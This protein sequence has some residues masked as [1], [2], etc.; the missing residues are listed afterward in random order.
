MPALTV[1]GCPTTARLVEQKG[2]GAAKP[3]A[4]LAV[5][6]AHQGGA[7]KSAFLSGASNVRSAKVSGSSKASRKAMVTHAALAEAPKPSTAAAVEQLNFLTPEMAYKVANE[8]GTPCYV[9]DMETLKRQADTT[10]RFPNAYG[11]TVRYA[12]KSSPNA[13]ILQVFNAKG[14]HIDASSGFECIRAMEA[15]IPASHISLSSQELPAFFPDLCA[16]GVKVNCCSLSQLERYGQA[17]PGTKVG[18][19]FNPGMG[20][21]GNKKTNVGGTSSSFGI[22]HESLP[23]VQAIA[24]KYNLTVERIHTH[25]GSGSDPAVWQKVSGMSLDICRQF[26][27][28]ETLNLGGGYK[29]GR[30]EGEPSTDLELIGNPVVGEFEQFAEETGRKLRLEIEPG[31][32]LM[33]NSCSVVST[34]Q[35]VVSTGEDGYNFL[36][37]DMGMT[38]VLRPSLYGSQHPLVVVPKSMKVAETE[39]AKYVV[40]GH[41]C[42]SGDLVSPAPDEPET[43]FQRPMGKAEIGDLMVIEGTG[44]YCSSMSTKNYNS[45]PE[46]AEVMVDG[47]NLYL[48]RKRQDV[49]QI[50]MN[51]MPLPHGLV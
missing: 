34:V 50:W 11:L 2:Q 25:I 49:H 37:M 30:M 14:L 10:L 48:V 12:M 33:A 7:S 18:V 40:V 3:S 5:K 27:D 16:K 32:F 31:T 41:C 29:V 36:K 24:A 6:N 23:E 19:R 21:G 4:R 42:E 46:A 22:W 51:E 26:P 8:V 1:L 39:E 45:F 17:L 13:A 43:L 20:S 47:D 15:G 28:V 44:A 38:D 9:Y 35:D